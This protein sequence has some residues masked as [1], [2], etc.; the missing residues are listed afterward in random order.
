VPVLIGTSGW[1]YRDWRG[2]F[3][4]AGLPQAKWLEFYAERFRVQEVNNAFYR[5]PEASTFSAWAER[6][7]DDFVMVVKASRFLTHIKRL[8]DPEEPVQ[9]FVERAAC[10]GRKLGPILLQLPPSMKADNERLDRTL[11]LFP[12]DW[13]L[14]VEF[15]HESWHTEETCAVLR[16]HGAAWCLA[17]SPRRTVPAWKTAAWGYLRLHEGTGTP[18]PCYTRGALDRWAGR[19]ADLYGP[20]EEVFVFFNND[21]RACAIRDAIGFADACR[22]HG[23]EPTRVP[24]RREVAVVR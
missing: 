19:L 9:R 20:E 22:R 14:A 6:T 10:L 17:D 1:Q 23:L 15:R 12:S 24:E 16:G 7:P 18:R 2:S 3:Y 8:K 11:G 4:P 13:R 21:P 5:L